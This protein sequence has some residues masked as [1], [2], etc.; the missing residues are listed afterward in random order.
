MKAFRSADPVDGVIDEVGRT[1]STR[2]TDKVVTLLADALAIS[3]FFKS[4]AVSH[5]STE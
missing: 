1:H 4:V 5:T 2:I 3:P